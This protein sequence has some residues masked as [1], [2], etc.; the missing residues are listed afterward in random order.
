MKLKEQESSRSSNQSSE[1]ACIRDPA[2]AKL[3]AVDEY[4]VKSNDMCVV[5]VKTYEEK[6]HTHVIDL[7][8][9]YSSS[10]G[11]NAKL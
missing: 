7:E 6:P 5:K 11:S 4:F 2:N 3:S 9:V 10:T 8:C 1:L